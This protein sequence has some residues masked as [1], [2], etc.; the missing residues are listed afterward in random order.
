MAKRTIKPTFEMIDIADLTS[1]PVNAREHNPRNIGMIGDSLQEVGAW[2]SIGIDEDG[3]V[4]MGNGVVEAAQERG[5]RRVL[6]VDADGETVVA[7]RRTGLSQ[8]MKHRAA[9]YDNRSAELSSW[10]TERVAALRLAGVQTDN[11]WTNPERIKLL[12]R[13]GSGQSEDAPVAGDAAPA[14]P[15]A[16]A[17]GPSM[18]RCP[19]CGHVWAEQDGQ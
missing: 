4:Y 14:A 6:V 8:E 5:L 16:S 12:A 18:C 3:V 2:R 9:L 11:L 17:L 10:N 13:V 19:K 7:V 1:D 15:A